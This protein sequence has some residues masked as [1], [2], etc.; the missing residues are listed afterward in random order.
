MNFRVVLLLMVF[1]CG[2]AEALDAAAER[3][4]RQR[5]AAER[6]EIDKAYAAR[7]AECHQRFVVTSCL[8]AARRDRREALERLRHQQVLLDEA[9]RKQRA[10]QRIDE[11]RAKVSSDEAKRR[12][13]EVRAR[14]RDTRLQ[15][16][17]A[18]VQA[19]ASV[20]AAPQ[21]PA[22]AAPAKPAKTPN[23]K[24]VSDYEKRQA[25]AKA[26]RAAVERRN[27]ERAAKGE[28]AKPLPVPSAASAP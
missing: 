5:I 9:Q 28:P 24:R 14:E 6:A 20:P 12:E 22:S 26:H 8:D 11:I 16:Q 27:A 2:S 17:A 15:K 18:R 23:A 19:A 7:E 21:A 25:E 1:A 4:E 3:V 10:A 13:A